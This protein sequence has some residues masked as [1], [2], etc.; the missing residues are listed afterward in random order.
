MFRIAGFVAGSALA[1]VAILLLLGV[2][3]LATREPIAKATAPTP[4]PQSQNLPT[5]KPLDTAPAGA[6]TLLPAGCG[7]SDP[8]YYPGYWLETDGR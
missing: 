6:G 2:P 5:D 8:A 4:V 7:D 1:V 3:Q